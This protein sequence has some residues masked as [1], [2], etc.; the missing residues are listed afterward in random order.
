[1]DRHASTGKLF[2]YLGIGKPILAVAPNGV[3]ESIIHRADLGT[4]AHPSDMDKIKQ[5][6]SYWINGGYRD[7]NLVR[8]EIRQYDVRSKAKEMAEVL[9]RI[10]G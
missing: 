1:M 8:G 4:V 10:T 5:D 6:I 3:A 7:H 2:D 9:E